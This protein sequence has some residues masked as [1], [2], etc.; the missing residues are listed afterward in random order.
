MP[1]YTP[2]F[3]SMAIIQSLRK[4]G[5]EA[6]FF[7]IDYFR[8]SHTQ[9]EAYFRENQ[10][11]V[12]GISAVVSTAYEYTKYLSNLIHA[13][14]PKT[15]I[16]VGGNL[17]ASAEIL[18]RKSKVNFCVVGDGELIIQDLIHVLYEFPL[19]YDRLRATKGIC[20][21]DEKNE[22]YF[23]GYGAKPSAEEIDWP[24]YGILERDGSLQN[25]ILDPSDSFS[26]HTSK[27]EPGKK[28]ATVAMSKGCVNHCT[29]CH[30]WEKGF[31]TRPVDQVINHV[32]YLK[33]HYNVGFI[34]FSDENFGAD[35]KRTWELASRLGE[36]GVAWR[37]AGVRSRTVNKESLQHWKNNGCV[38]A[39]FGSESGSQKILNIMEKNATVEENIN[40]LKWTVEAGLDTVIQL[41]IGMPGED[42]ET[43]NET[44]GFLKEV[45]SFIWPKTVPSELL[46]INYAQAL[47]GTP[48]YEYARQHGYIGSDID[49]EE[50]YLIAISDTNAASVDHFI[51]YSGQPLLK[52]LMW[53]P[54]IVAH[55]DAHHYMQQHGSNAKLSLFK[56][57]SYYTRIV[58]FK[59]GKRIKAR[60]EIMRIMGR[61]AD[62][63]AKDNVGDGYNFVK[64]SGYFNIYTSIKPGLLLLNPITRRMF[65]PLLAIG[66]ALYASGGSPMRAVKLLLEHLYRS[67]MPGTRKPEDWPD[68]SLRKTITIAP[69]SSNQ[70]GEDKMLPLRTGR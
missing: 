54:L 30:R 37:A 41:V 63:K 51:N 21:L 56:I 58:G 67:V 25:Y 52:A 26:G 55:I 18:L 19:N 7:N 28:M 11:D 5:E 49:E 68:K 59:L 69:S 2:P 65:L 1:T 13:V 60:L 45:S 3:G 38:A 44:I 57:G 34:Q 29:F 62:K 16:V 31:R 47:P 22:F 64:D 40:A 20:F 23:T 43:I 35:R 33:E 46:S 4:I 70:N 12:V 9:V 27:Q 15:A 6:E 61:C 36:L 66:T 10:F 32:R 50:K 53:R 14:S 48:L 42:D 24:D 17:A 39:V 8:Y